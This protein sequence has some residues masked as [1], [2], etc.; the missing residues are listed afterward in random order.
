VDELVLGQ[1]GEFYLLP[2]S[3]EGLSD[4]AGEFQLEASRP[5]AS[6]KVRASRLAHRH[7]VGPDALPA[8][9][10][11]PRLAA[12]AAQ[13]GDWRRGLLP[14]LLGVSTVYRRTVL[15]CADC[16][17]CIQDHLSFA[18]CTMRHCYKEL[19]N[20][21]C[22]GSR[23]DGSCEVHPGQ[24]CIWNLAYRETL[25]AGEDPH[26]FAITLLPPRDWS[27]DGTNAVLNRYAGMDNLSRRVP[28]GSRPGAEGAAD[29]G[30]R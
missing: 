16:G 6:L 8:Q 22:G 24:P 30:D 5:R 4:G 27:L 9:Y 25:A 1:P 10:L 14:R 26:R 13:G 18:G 12:A 21:P 11:G 7:V 19:R 28:S 17:D 23:V 20:G 15:G 3:T 2:P 29:A